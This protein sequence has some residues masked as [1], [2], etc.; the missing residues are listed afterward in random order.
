MEVP[1]LTKEVLR[2]L[3]YRGEATMKK[4]AEPPTEWAASPEY[5]ITYCVENLTRTAAI[6]RTDRTLVEMNKFHE[7]VPDFRAVFGE[8]FCFQHQHSK[9]RGS[10]TIIQFNHFLTAPFFPRDMGN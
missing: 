1:V 3:R 2:D 8:P 6:S 7:A 10:L 4:W 9:K 5:F